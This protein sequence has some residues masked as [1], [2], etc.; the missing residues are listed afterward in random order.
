M[1]IR[2]VFVAAVPLVAIIIAGCGGGGGGSSGGGATTISYSGNTSAA[3]LTSNNAASLSGS[4][5]VG[6]DL[7][8]TTARGLTGEQATSGEVRSAQIARIMQESVTLALSQPTAGAPTSATAVQQQTQTYPCLSSGTMT[9]SLSVDNVTGGFTGSFTY[10]NCAN[11][12]NETVSGQITVSGTVNTSTSAI[13]SLTINGTLDIARGA[14]SYAFSGTISLGYTYSGTGALTGATLTENID[15]RNSAGIYFKVQ[16]YSVTVSYTGTYHDVSINSA[17]NP[18]I[19]CH[20]VDGCVSVYTTTAFR[21][22]TGS[23][24]PSSGALVV[25]GANSAKVRLTATSS[26]AYLVEWDISPVDGTYESS[27]AGT[28]SSL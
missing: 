4:A 24:W 27:S 22:N 2:H 11:T 19:F 7:G 23:L 3:T 17:G 1:N 5:L 10:T 21:Y 12:T 28:W 13:T 15:V 26:T 25:I 9:V 6:G 16:N 14:S 8:T 18:A 20:S